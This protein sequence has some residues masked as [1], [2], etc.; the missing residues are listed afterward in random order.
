MA[1]RCFVALSVSPDVVG[2]IE[3]AVAELR[4]AAERA[5]SRVAWSRPE[6]W[7]VT[8]KF[9]GEIDEDR[10]MEVR[11]ALAAL[12]TGG[13]PIEL[14]AVGTGT[15]PR[16]GT[17]RVLIVMVRGGRP[18]LELAA[19]VE[20]GLSA[21]GFARERRPFVGHLTVGR[22]RDARGWRRW[23]A[24]VRKGERTPFGKWTATAV[25]LYRS[26]LGS[27]PARYSLIEE[28]PLGGGVRAGAGG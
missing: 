21:L 7:H 17:P 24:A 2:R 26:E 3:P 13:A 18:L 25:G 23:E 27:G 14:E 20:D 10:V 11:R 19:A 12:A 4:K 15:L 9:L 16:R 6:G 28:Y 1:V 5:G 8:L 22:V